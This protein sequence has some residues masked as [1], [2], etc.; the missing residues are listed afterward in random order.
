LPGTLF[1]QDLLRATGRSWEEWI[2]ALQPAIGDA[3]PHEQIRNFIRREYEAAEDWAEWMAVMY[4]QLL[5]RVPVGVT[6]DAGVQIGVRKTINA[7]KERVWNFLVSEEGVSLWIGDTP[8]LSLRTGYEFK[9]MEGVSGKLT[10]VKPGQKLRLTWQLPEWERPSRLQLILLSTP[11]GST[12]VAVHQEMLDD[13]Y[14]REIMKRHWT[15]ILERIRGR[16]EDES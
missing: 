14:T 12:T 2:A 5:G 1:K 7:T 9:S 11:S 10:V 13:V 16:T 15:Q 8:P 6:K 3:W 4:G